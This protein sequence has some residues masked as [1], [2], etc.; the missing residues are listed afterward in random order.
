MTNF[1]VYVEPILLREG[2]KLKN[3]FKYKR[4]D[5]N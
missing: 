5:K 1:F 2:K 3:P 4:R